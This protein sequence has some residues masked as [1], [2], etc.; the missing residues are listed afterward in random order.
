MHRRKLL[1]IGAMVALAINYTS[2]Y[3]ITFVWDWPSL[4][5]EI[6]VNLLW[7][8]ALSFLFGLLIVDI[9]KTLFYTLGSIV[10]AIPLATV[11]ISAPSM[12]LTENIEL[13]DLDI[14][15][16]ITHISRLF[17]LQITFIMIAAIIGCFVSDVQLGQSET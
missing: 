13:L 6:P 14:T 16:A 10:M 11:A 15:L 9:K 1:E 7:M 4:N 12:A 2:T 17:I 5:S 3:V 8:F